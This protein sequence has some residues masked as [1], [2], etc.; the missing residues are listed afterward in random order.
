MFTCNKCGQTNSADSW[1]TATV[2]AIRKN[3]IDAKLTPILEAIQE[4][5]AGTED[6][7]TY[8]CSNCG[9]SNK[10]R[11]IASIGGE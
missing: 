2:M 9:K 5:K 7:F 10:L 6:S 3:D 11:K 1:N 4:V 8:V